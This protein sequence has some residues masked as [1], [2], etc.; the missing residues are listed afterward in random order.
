[1][2]SPAVHGAEI[3]VR[4]GRAKQACK[5]CNARRVRCNVLEKRP[6]DKCEAAGVSCEIVPSRR[7]RYAC[8]SLVTYV[9]SASLGIDINSRRP[10]NTKFLERPFQDNN[11]HSSVPKRLSPEVQDTQEHYVPDPQNPAF[12]ETRRSGHKYPVSSSADNT[13]SPVSSHALFFGES[14]LLTCVASPSAVNNLTPAPTEKTQKRLVYPISDAVNIRA[15][16]LFE[17]H[18]LPTSSSKAQYLAK[19]GAFTLPASQDCVTVLRAYFKWF[20]PCFPIVDRLEIANKYNQGEISPLLLQ[21]ILFIGASFC[22][23]ETV[24]RMGFKDRPE[25]KSQ[26]YNRAKILYDADWDQMILLFF[27]HCF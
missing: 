16:Q 12:N 8:S 11:L 5:A 20:H 4:R 7:G 19:G 22:D 26:L 3:R 23:D 10:M 14:N 27:N 25:A 15:S 1:M 6:C 18:T 24:H 13:T 21:A 17:E 9:L 2:S